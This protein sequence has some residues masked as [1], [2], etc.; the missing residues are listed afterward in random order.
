MK[1]NKKTI[2]IILLGATIAAIAILSLIFLALSVSDSHYKGLSKE[3]K[4]IAISYENIAIPVLEKQITANHKDATIKDIYTARYQASN[5]DYSSSDGISSVVIAEVKTK[6]KLFYYAYDVITKK[7]Y[8][9]EFYNDVLNDVKTAFIKSTEI[10]ISNTDY[11]FYIISDICDSLSL[12]SEF[13]KQS[14]INGQY[15]L[16]IGI[17]NSNDF[18]ESIEKNESYYINMKFS[19]NDSF[20]YKNINF[21]SFFSEYTCP[22]LIEFFDTDSNLC[23]SVAF[24]ESKNIDIVYNTK[25]TKKINDFECLYNSYSYSLEIIPVSILKKEKLNV[26]DSTYT[27]EDNYYK[28][29]IIKSNDDSSNS[30]SNSLGGRTTIKGINSGVSIKIPNKYKLNSGVYAYTVDSGTPV[31]ITND[32]SYIDIPVEDNKD[33][34]SHVITFYTLN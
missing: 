11:Q 9:T 32:M 2:L 1:H 21:E 15:F 34:S 8:S 23:T 30:V 10:D 25:R 31:K 17:K 20:N 14:S 24:D 27:P 4:N 22:A 26:E 13:Q 3:A 33:I 28:I 19:H 12:D 18:K 6:D 5:T 16:P 7:T 29:N